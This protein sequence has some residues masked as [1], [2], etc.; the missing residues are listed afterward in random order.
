M[1]EIRAAIQ[2]PDVKINR[3]IVEGDIYLR[4]YEVIK[5][6]EIIIWYL[7]EPTGLSAMIP[8]DIVDMLNKI[9]SET[10]ND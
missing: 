4:W 5:D 7:M 9:Y 10:T 2:T 1:N 8:D 6:Q 3:L